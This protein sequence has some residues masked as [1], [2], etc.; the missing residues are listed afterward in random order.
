MVFVLRFLWIKR[1]NS[2]G[3]VAHNQRIACHHHPMKIQ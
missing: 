3:M 1:Q 2:M